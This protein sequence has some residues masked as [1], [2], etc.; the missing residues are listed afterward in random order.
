MI[1]VDSNYFPGGTNVR[2][3]KPVDYSDFFSKL[4]SIPKFDV[5]STDPWQVDLRSRD[6]TEINMSTSLADLMYAD[7][8]SK[9]QWPGSDK[10]PI[11]FDALKIMETGKDPGLGMR[12]LHEQGVTGKGVGI[13]IID[14]TL[15]VD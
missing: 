2:H 15:L 3:P 1:Q 6:L 12:A 7:F 5:N 14:Q 4:T 11:D 9:T 8:D 10:L 13:A